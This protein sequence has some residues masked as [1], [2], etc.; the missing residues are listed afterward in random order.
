MM[1]SQRATCTVI[2]VI[3]VM[4]GLTPSHVP[5]KI[6]TI[7]APESMGYLAEDSPIIVF[8]YSHGQFSSTV[9]PLDLLLE[10]ELENLG[11]TV[12]W[13]W[14]GINSAILSNATGLVIGSIWEE[15]NA[16]LPEEI[17][18]IQAWFLSGSKFLWVGTDD[19]F[20]GHTYI[21][22]NMNLILQ[23]IGSHVYP[24]P[25]GVGDPIMNC[26]ASYRVI[27]NG[28]SE[29]EFVAPIVANVSG[30]LMHSPTMLYG[31]ESPTNPG[32]GV[33]PVPLEDVTIDNVFPLL[34]YSQYATCLD[35]DIVPPFAHENGDSG[36]FV[37]ATLETNLGFTNNC[38]AIVS[39]ANPYGRYQPMFTSDYYGKSLEGDLFVKQAINFG[40]SLASQLSIM[41]PPDIIYEEGAVGYYIAWQ[42]FDSNP[43]LYNITSDHTLI[44]EGAWNSSSEIFILSVDGLSQ[45]AYNFTLTVEN[46]A[47]VTLSDAVLVTVVEQHPPEINHPEDMNIF[48]G[49]DICQIMW[50]F[51]DQSLLYYNISLNSEVILTEFLFSAQFKRVIINLADLPVGVHNYTIHVIDRAFLDVTDTVFVEV[52]DLPI[53]TTTTTTATTTAT[54]TTSD[55]GYDIIGT[56]TFI[57]SVGSS[58]VIIVIAIIII[59]RR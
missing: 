16:F 34:Y 10:T 51:Y 42:A 14:G 50:N 33:S 38:V 1:G 53:S 57:I 2:F 47:N 20:S 5:V 58:I 9:E 45:G 55:G 28:T 22:D 26:N 24:E 54:N 12:V 39:G 41:S 25:V 32:V 13:A 48:V 37:C 31:S 15:S 59:R 18:A 49:D 29:N 4:V 8:D 40:M 56:M 23:G 19:D 11:Y 44:R 21:N 46:E 6:E 7:Q 3:L 35:Q 36:E 52:L 43:K 30:V 17:L 27:A